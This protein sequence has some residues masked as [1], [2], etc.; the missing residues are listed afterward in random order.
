MPKKSIEQLLQDLEY[1]SQNDIDNPKWTLDSLTNLHESLSDDNF[2]SY[3]VYLS[4]RNDL[5]DEDKD[6][7]EK[8]IKVK[9][10]L[11]DREIKKRFSKL[12]D[13]SSKA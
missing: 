6:T 11:E 3:I 1:L 10:A 13:V 12:E 5:S 2:M 7:I 4:L 8:I 9:R